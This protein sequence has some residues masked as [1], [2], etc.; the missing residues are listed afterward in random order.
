MSTL[1]Y[2]VGDQRRLAMN[3]TDANGLDADPATITVKVFL[4]NGTLDEYVFGV[5]AEVGKASLGNF[6]VDLL[7][8]AKGRHTVRF[9][10]AG[11]VNS[12][13]TIDVYIRG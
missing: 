13:A 4:P 1:T 6:F 8:T 2:D 3:F 10:G 11:T 12:A 7:F 9:V 5:D